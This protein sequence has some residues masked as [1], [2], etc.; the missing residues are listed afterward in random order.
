MASDVDWKLQE[1]IPGQ[2]IKLDAEE[3]EKKVQQWHTACLHLFKALNEENPDAAN[4]ATELRHKIEDFMKHLPLIKYLSSEAILDED[5]KLIQDAVKIDNLERN[6]EL[7]LQRMIEEDLNQY[8]EEIEEIS[9]R[10]E[11][12][13]SLRSKLRFMK[14]DLKEFKIELFTYKKTG[15]YVLKGF[16][17]INTKL[18]DQIVTTQAM[19]GSQFMGGSLQKDTRIWEKRLNDI[20]ELMEEIT[21]C[22]RTWMYLEPIFASDEIHKQMPTE[23]ANFKFVDT[24]WRQTMEAIVNEPCINELI[25]RDNIK[26]NFEDANRKLEAI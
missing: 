2:F 19:L 17:E 21:K 3:I 8:I 26:P 4:V 20:S 24:L 9:M 12:K 7:T 22:Q 13:F 1:W 25:E 6:E 18:D 14:D 16:D 5:W 11:K 10:A 15:T 23:G